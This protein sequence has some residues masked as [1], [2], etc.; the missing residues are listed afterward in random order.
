[1]GNSLSSKMPITHGQ[2]K[3]SPVNAC[4]RASRDVLCGLRGS[5]SSH[6][7]GFT[8]VVAV[9]D[10]VVVFRDGAERGIVELIDRYLIAAERHNL[11]PVI[12]VNK[13]DLA[14]DEAICRK[15]LQ[16]YLDL[17]HR[18]LFTSALTG[19]GIEELRDTLRGKTTVLAGLSGVGKSSLLA[20]VQ[21][22]LQLRMGNVSEHSGKGRHAPKFTPAFVPAV[23]R[24]AE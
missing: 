5:L 17:G 2:M 7:I 3:S 15:T 11:R 10:Q 8:N 19:V 20:A 1:M 14:E 24:T 13:V 6:D 22:G 12:C 18:V 16:P 23:N 9:G 4:L 21:P